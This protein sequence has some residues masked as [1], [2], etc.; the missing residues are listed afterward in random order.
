MLGEQFSIKRSEIPQEVFD[1]AEIEAKAIYESDYASNFSLSGRPR[2]FEDI[3]KDALLG[4]LGE[5]FLKTKF[6]F[7]NDDAKWHDLISPA[8][9]RTEVKTWR[10]KYMTER[11][12]LSEIKKLRN[13]KRSTRQWFFSTEAI[14]I[15]YNEENSIF[16]IEA[17]YKI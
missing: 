14:I 15:S 17:I 7:I 8:G 13:R 2:S 4:K 16:T 1:D 9:T 5:Y 10:K 11:G 12:T 6:G 3:R